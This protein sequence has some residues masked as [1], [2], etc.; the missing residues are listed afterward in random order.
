MPTYGDFEDYL[1]VTAICV[2]L[3]VVLRY[4]VGLDKKSGWFFFH[5][6]TNAFVLY[7]S[8]PGMFAILS[9]VNESLS[10]TIEG[11][12]RIGLGHAMVMAIHLHHVI[13]YSTNLMDVIH[14]VISAGLV[15]GLGYLYYMRNYVHYSNVFMCGLPGGLDYFLLG[16]LEL[17][18][19]SKGDEK[20]Y[21]MWLNNGLRW[22]G[23]VTCMMCVALALMANPES[24]SFPWVVFASITTLHLS[25]ALYYSQR[26]TRNLGMFQFREQLDSYGV[27]TDLKKLK[28]NSKTVTANG[29]HKKKN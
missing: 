17:K 12:D 13:F 24:A 27:E 19:I 26:V 28:D 15:G 21:N 16:L 3:E 8:L 4:I 2:A 10:E 18:I 25:N 22:P 7:Y 5:A 9:N 20:F 1:I 23:E 6:I 29:G 11:D 14:H